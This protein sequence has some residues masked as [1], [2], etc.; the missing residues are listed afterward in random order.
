MY[1]SATLS[2]NNVLHILGL[3]ILSYTYCKHC[4]KYCNVSISIAISIAILFMVALW[5]RADHYIFCPVVS[6]SS[7]FFKMCQI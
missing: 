3:L 1:A 5:N 7:I 4:N 6:S 2:K